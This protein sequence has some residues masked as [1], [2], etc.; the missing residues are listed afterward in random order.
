MNVCVLV[1]RITRSPEMKYT[2][3]GVAIC[4]FSIAV[5]RRYKNAA[6]EKQADF[7]DCV[8]WRQQAEF[9]ATYLDKGRLVAINAHAEQQT[10]VQQDGTKRSK[11]QFVVEDIKGLDKKPDA[12]EP[13]IDFE[14][15]PTGVEDD[16]Y[17]PFEGSDV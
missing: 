11:V 1:G 7:F 5:D 10:W 2:G 9:T 16:G 13:R 8:A 17:D 6:G 12:S 15:E 14:A 4:T 3:A